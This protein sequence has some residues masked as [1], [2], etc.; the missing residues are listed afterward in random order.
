MAGQPTPSHHSRL[1][2]FPCLPVPPPYR[3]FLPQL[4][5]RSLLGILN[6]TSPALDRDVANTSCDTGLAKCSR[7]QAT[8]THLLL[9]PYCPFSIYMPL[10]VWLQSFL[11]GVS[12]GGA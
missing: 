9:R 7:L 12:P 6:T 3:G 2:P 8:S 5:L 11:P 4:S 1:A 10:A